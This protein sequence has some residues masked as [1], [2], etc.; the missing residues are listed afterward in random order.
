M[1]SQ[2]LFICYNSINGKN[3]GSVITKRNLKALKQIFNNIDVIYIKNNKIFKIQI[4]QEF[5]KAICNLH[6]YAGGLLSFKI[7][8]IINMINKKRYDII[9]IDSSLYGVLCKKIKYKYPYI[10]IIVFFHNSEYQFALER[11]KVDGCIYLPLLYSAYYNER[12]SLKYADSIIFLNKRD[13]NI[14]KNKYNIKINNKYYIIPISIEDRFINKNNYNTNYQPYLLFVGSAFFA[15]IEAVRWLIKNIVGKVKYKIIVVGHG[16]KSIFKNINIE[17]IEIHDYVE[18]LSEIY[19]GA[20]CVILPIHY[21]S[22]MKVKT[23][24]ALMYGKKIIGSVEAF[25]G[26]KIDES[27]MLVCHTIKDY[28]NAINNLDNRKYY[29]Q[30]RNLYL[31]NYS[32]CVVNLK[33]KNIINRGYSK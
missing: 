29:Q 2:A 28:L 8:Y 27:I 16:M 23:C 22:G 33:I 10:P 4:I 7:K 21:G 6:G 13:Y 17:N 31:T 9:F 18:D 19:A 30:A 15:N 1:K 32:D 14:T 26:Y 5:Y 12:L 24:E 3:G 20:T 25:E 11:I